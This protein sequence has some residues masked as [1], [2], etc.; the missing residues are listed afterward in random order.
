[1]SIN[2]FKIIEID[3][4]EIGSSKIAQGSIVNDATLNIN[5]DGANATSGATTLKSAI[6]GSGSLKVYGGTLNLANSNNCGYFA[7]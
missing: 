3:Q 5:Y 2:K 6:S 1:M 4:I 7:S